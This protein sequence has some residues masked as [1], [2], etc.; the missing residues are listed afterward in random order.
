MP[1]NFNLSPYYD[2]FDESKGFHRI[3][4]KPGFAV[5]A[6]ELTQ[7]QTQLQNQ[8]TKFGNHIFKEGSVVLGGNF[9]RTDVDYITISRNY[10]ISLLLGQDITGNTSNAVARVLKTSPVS[11][12]V[13]KLYIQYNSGNKFVR[14][15]NITGT[16]I[17]LIEK[18]V[19]SNTFSG[20]ATMFSIESGVFYAYG[21]FVYCNPQSIIISEDVLPSC[22]VGLFVSEEIID[23]TQ[24]TSLLDPALGSYNYSAPGADRYGISLDLIYYPYDVSQETTEEEN[25]SPNFI[26]LVRILNGVIVNENKIP[27]Y[28]EIEKTLA[29]RTYDESGDYTVRSFGI[30]INDHLGANDSLLSLQ[31]EPG[32][33]YV[34]G[35][36][37]ETTS[38]TFLDLEKSRDKASENEFPIYINYG[39]F[40]YIKGLSKGSIDFTD[41]I[42]LDLRD[43]VRLTSG[44]TLGNCVSRYIE[45]DS[46]DGSN[47]VYKIYVDQL[48][49]K[50]NVSIA[51]VLSI[52]TSTFQANIASNLYSTGVRLEGNDNPTYIIKI[53]K[54]Y[55]A[56]VNAS[57][58]SYQ[59]TKRLTSDFNLGG[60]YANSTVTNSSVNQVFLGNLG[61]LS[62]TDTRSLFVFVVHTTTNAS[63]LP[64]GTVL[65]YST[66]NL[67]VNII[68][69]T[70]MQV[71][72]NVTVAFTSSIFAKVSVS[73]A[74][75]KTKTA[76]DGTLVISGASLTKAN[77]I[78]KISLGKSDCFELNSIIA[79]NNANTRYDYTGRYDFFTGQTNVLYDHGYIKLKAGYSDPI[80]D[81]IANLNSVT[82][83]FRYYTH[84]GEA[85][86]FFD[87]Q[88]YP[89][90]DK[91]PKFTSSTGEIYDLHDCFDFRARRIDNSTGISGSLLG[92][93]STLITT[94]FEYY[95]GRIDK[96]ILTKD[97]K[98]TILKGVPSVN[99]TTPVDM[100][101]AMGLYIINIPPY[102][103]SKDNV[104]TTYIEN[105]RYTMR[106][107]GRIEKRVEKLE[108][109]TSLSL[110]EKQ[111]ADESI[112]SDIPTVDR[113]K[114]GI[115]VDSFAGHSVG[116]VKHPAYRCAIDYQNKI[117]R[118]SFAS[119]VVE[120]KYGSGT[121]TVL[122][123]DIVTLDYD[124]EIL[125]QQPLS[126]SWVNVNPYSVFLWDGVCTLN[127]ATDTWV[128][129]T[130]KPDVVVNLN[131]END[132]FTTL[133]DNVENPAS[134]GV[135]WSD[136]SVVGKGVPQVTSSKST[137]TDKITSTTSTSATVTTTTV[138]A[139]TTNTTDTLAKVGLEISTGAVQTVTKDLGTKIVDVSLA[140]YIRSR[141]INFAAH[142]MRPLTNVFALFD[143]TDVTTYC[144]PATEININ[145]S[146]FNSNATSISLTSNTAIT[147]DIIF[148]RKDRIYV[149]EKNG[150][151]TTNA[152]FNWVSS[153]GIIGTSTVLSVSRKSGLTTNEK[154]DMCG[155]FSIPNNSKIKFRVGEKQFKLTDSVGKGATTVAS[156]KYVAQGLSKTQQDTIISTRIA[157]VEI[158]P[159]LKTMD[160]TRTSNETIVTQSVNV[161]PIVPCAHTQAGGVTG[162][163]EFKVDL[164]G[165]IG[166][167]GI[168]FD[169]NAYIPDRYTIIWDGQEF[170]SGFVGSSDWNQTLWS[171]GYPGVTSSASVGSLKFNKTKNLPST[172]IVRVEAPIQGTTWNFKVI[173]PGEAFVAPDRTTSVGIGMSISTPGSIGFT[174][175]HAPRTRLRRTGRGFFG[176]EI[177]TDPG[178]TSQVAQLQYYLETSGT[179]YPYVRI[180]AMSAT[181]GGL[182]H[183]A[184]D[185]DT[186]PHPTI[187]GQRYG[188]AW[189]TLTVTRPENGAGYG[190]DYTG[191]ARIYQDAARTV[192]VDALPFQAYNGVSVWR[193]DAVGMPQ[194]P[195]DP[196]AQTFF[197]NEDQYPEGVFLDSLNLYFR[198]K[199]ENLPVL[200]EIRPVV[201][202]YPSSTEIVPFSVVSLSGDEVQV[203][204]NASI[205]TNFRFEAPVYLPPG[206]HAFVVR[207]GST[208]FEVYTAV[209][210][211]TTLKNPNVRV[212]QQPALGSLFKSQNSSTW[213][214]VQE[215]DIMFNLI[216]CVFPTGS[217]NTGTVNL[218]S[219]YKA[220]G[221]LPYDVLFADGENLDFAATNIQY[222]YKTTDLGGTTDSS[223]TRYQLGQNDALPARR[224]V[225]ENVGT[226]LQFRM[227]LSTTSPHVS[228][229]I[230]LSRFTSAIVRNNVNNAD[231][232]RTDFII[233]DY[234]LGYTQNANVTISA[235]HGSGAT[236]M[237]KYNANTNKLE[238]IV[239][240]S[241]S[242]YIGDVTAT[243]DRSSG[244]T[245]NA[246]V[247]VKNEIN[248]AIGNA[249]SRYITRKVTLASGFESTDLKSYVLANL[250]TGTSIQMYYKVAPESIDDFDSEPWRM[251]EL[252][253]SGAP[254]QTGFVEFKYKTPGDTALPSGERFKTFSIKITMLSDNSVKVP[255]IK[256][257]RV[258]AIDE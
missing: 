110:L 52:N 22:R 107:I 42:T 123:G 142:S 186:L 34:K 40:F 44:N 238:I 237:A 184:W 77:L 137:S 177:T 6:R 11:D 232:K 190:V 205:E 75:R 211:E 13:A 145:P 138:T 204:A 154:G 146:T 117:L 160:T 127:P 139:Q 202:G 124:F 88:S 91:I 1:S 248:G 253:S 162:T 252:E 223:W 2:D 157:T 80:S 212:T 25:S 199:S 172:A 93:P 121:K 69:E 132:V 165:N 50:P 102:T 198:K 47:A 61:T 118:P 98:L 126:S 8:I 222:Y 235:T 156:T 201:N 12:D 23:A 31:V 54:N 58:T 250:P 96:L 151:F 144:T 191:I 105:K 87:V 158:N 209:L 57:E 234:G 76:T 179:P 74:T 108:Y 92:E 111:A 173:C 17:T 100:P 220:K 227:Y 68:N 206:E 228:P 254:S 133:V 134:V 207:S 99:P 24:D 136:W 65:D 195:S 155:V 214:P 249:I 64:V 256:D 170:T 239:T 229:V 251:M 192:L 94:D 233:T 246:V 27:I 210:G 113:F 129:T 175:N 66:H 187:P 180:S 38:S 236:A 125:T 141:L 240:N 20:T 14:N 208:D 128:D 169:S 15:E 85:S 215:E 41:N 176:F 225:R 30:K 193:N 221:T 83:S 56:S 67:R 150:I 131:G 51:N 120:F 19:D 257:L 216:K 226:D 48:Q 181:N 242:G 90:Y 7:I 49:L 32:K 166:V 28:S 86:G 115:L 97:R 164:G 188:S 114:N 194:P 218:L 224:M 255:Q 59:T 9:T 148:K 33:A 62:Q 36:E 21:N 159:V 258:I 10:D 72:T 241:G 217:A 189:P 70:T 183:S 37:F 219:D 149:A 140:P 106:D 78:G 104:S 197:V 243:I 130:T 147:A 182:S 71:T 103:Q 122:N 5:Q 174:W 231:L 26:E 185:L 79:T 63:V 213:T 82:V 135:K 230:D 178:I 4:F 203:S 81:G 244:A 39:K 119:N 84:A 171:R 247:S 46:Q 153:A 109:Y 116:D 196:L 89:D 35:Y 95:L 168:T 29:R 55:V 18:T 16:D 112:P 43:N 3:L 245:A 152:T 167:A 163:H 200:V 45:Y 101:D 73:E 143:D 60:P 53:P 161:V